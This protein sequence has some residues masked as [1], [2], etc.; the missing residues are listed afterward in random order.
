M[1]RMASR[2]VGGGGLAPADGSSGSR[3][4]STV[5][6]GSSRRA[7]EDTPLYG[8]HA[9][10]SATRCLNSV[11]GSWRIP[12]WHHGT[13]TFP[14]R[15]SAPVLTSEASISTVL[16]SFCI[17][18]VSSLDACTRTF[19]A[20]AR[21]WE[22]R[23]T[24]CRTHCIP[25]MKQRPGGSHGV[26]P[27]DWLQRRPCTCRQRMRPSRQSMCAALH[28]VASPLQVQIAHQRHLHL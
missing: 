6:A 20:G 9:L 8:M 10:N 22:P 25:D 11:T 27:A 4:S 12:T 18:R 16:R 13:N 23:N 7:P 24:V 15:H 5:S 26:H 28:L 1:V 2:V 3:L 17:F 19:V 21:V 14:S